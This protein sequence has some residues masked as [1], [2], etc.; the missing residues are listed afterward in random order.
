M[1]LM[2]I[3]SDAE[4][5]KAAELA[6]IDRVFFDLEFINKFERQRG[7]NTVKSHNHIDQLP[8]IRAAV[9]TSELLVRTNP[10]NPGIGIEIDKAIDFGAEVLMLPMAVDKG[11]VECFVKNV[12]GRA[13]VCI[14]LESKQSLAR[15]DSMLGVDGIDEIF[16]GLNDLHLGLGLSFMFEMLSSGLI[17]FLAEKCRRRGIPFGFGGIA[18]IGEGLLSAEMILGEHYRLGSS[19]VILSR[20]FKGSEGSS[21]L[22]VQSL[23]QEVRKVREKE[24]ELRNWS[25]HEFES[26]RVKL[27]QTVESIVGQ[28]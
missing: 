27:I 25:S 15:A 18:R 23:S 3:V 17:E 7:L 10:I 9:K 14:M 16:I 26:N 5:A 20:T 22:S 12:A 24:A 13:K 1:K 2:I 4:A 8:Q 6:G 19:S 28:F 11:D 21:A